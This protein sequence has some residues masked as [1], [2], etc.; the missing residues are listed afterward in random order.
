[1]IKIKVKSKFQE[2]VA[3]RDRYLPQAR[4][5]GLEIKHNEEVMTIPAEEVDK[6]IVGRSD[7]PFVDRYSLKTHYL[8]YFKWSPDE[9]K[10]IKLL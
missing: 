2:K 9:V 6:K 5:E 3:I 7:K 8:L 1:M 10:Q 4:Q